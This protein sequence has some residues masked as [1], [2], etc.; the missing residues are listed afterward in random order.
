MGDIIIAVVVRLL[1]IGCGIISVMQFR[2]KGILFNNAYILSS[3]QEREK[4]DKKPHYR[5]SAVVF[6]LIAIIFLCLSVEV[7]TK[8]GWLF[9]LMWLFVAIVLI[10]AISSSIKSEVKK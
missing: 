4:I 2:E 10:Y 5:Q 8:T 1:A 6:A 7:V 3:K 9:G